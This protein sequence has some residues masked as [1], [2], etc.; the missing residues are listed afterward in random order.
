M[1]ALWAIA[2]LM[3]GAFAWGDDCRCE[4]SGKVVA[5]PD[6][7]SVWVYVDSARASYHFALAG[8]EPPTTDQPAGKAARDTLSAFV[9]G[10][11]VCVKFDVLCGEQDTVAASIHLNGQSV[12]YQMAQ[13][14]TPPS[15]TSYSPVRPVTPIT[16]PVAF[17][18]APPPRRPLLGVY[19]ALRQII[20]ILP[21]RN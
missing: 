7:G 8:V 17:N 16:S 15:F 5:V 1:K 6:G 2:F 18:H 4:V 21:G 20:P 11:E 10:Q 9:L 12:N 13:L 14:L 19:S 3:V